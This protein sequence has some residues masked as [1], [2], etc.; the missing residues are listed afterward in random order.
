MQALALTL[1]PRLG[2]PAGQCVHHPVRQHAP[3]WAVPRPELRCATASPTCTPPWSPATMVRPLSPSPSPRARHARLPRTLAT[4]VVLA[5]HAR[6]ARHACHARLPHT[7][8]T[9]ACH[10]RRTCHAHSPR[11]LATHVALAMHACHAR[12]ACHARLPRMSRLPCTLATHARHACR[13]CHARSPCV[14]PSP[15]TRLPALRA[16]SSSC[17][18]TPRCYCYLA[19]FMSY[20]S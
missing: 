17:P 5:T 14:Q 18:L 7:L 15:S 19:Q 2:P 12:R 20:I 16:R 4:H 6:H 11:T 9:H 1:P 8:A 13:T 10:A 3:L